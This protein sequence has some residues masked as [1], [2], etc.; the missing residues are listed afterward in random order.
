MKR[1]R[2]GGWGQERKEENILKMNVDKIK[3][4]NGY[5]QLTI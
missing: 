1:R 4:N 3:R 5:H 2:E